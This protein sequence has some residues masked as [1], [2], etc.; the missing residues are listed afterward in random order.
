M[1]ALGCKVMSGSRQLGF[2]CAKSS[3]LSPGY[4]PSTGAISKLNSSTSDTDAGIVTLYPNF[5]NSPNPAKM[6]WKYG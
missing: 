2:F 1:V 5:V 6:E 3:R 4:F